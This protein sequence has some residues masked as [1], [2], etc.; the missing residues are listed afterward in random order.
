MPRSCS[1]RRGLEGAEL[2][3]RRLP[4][5]WDGRH[6]AVRLRPGSDERVFAAVFGGLLEGDYELRVRGCDDAAQRVIV[7]GG[8][9]EWHRWVD[10]RSRHA[11]SAFG[12]TSTLKGKEHSHVG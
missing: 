8:A 10:V 3:I 7:R 12:S 9:I 2:E 1:Y 5:P 4:E 6:V 11:K